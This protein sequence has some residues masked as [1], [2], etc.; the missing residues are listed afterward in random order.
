MFWPVKLH[1]Q[2]SIVEWHSWNSKWTTSVCSIKGSLCPIT[3]CNYN[4]LNIGLFH[5]SAVFY[6]FICYQSEWIH[7][8]PIITVD[9]TPI[10]SK[11]PSVLL[12]SVITIVSISAI[13]PTALFL[14]V[15]L[16]WIEKISCMLT[17]VCLS[18]LKCKPFFVVAFAFHSYLYC[19][20]GKKR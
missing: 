20:C 16:S 17:V 5:S 4:C 6:T 14:Y 11:A 19:W 18:I 2:L 8:Q 15:I 3:I 13:S 7:T 10:Q 1:I 12:P 9:T